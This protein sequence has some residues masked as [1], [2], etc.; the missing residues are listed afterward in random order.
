ME[1]HLVSIRNRPPC[2]LAMDGARPGHA[3]SL[4]WGRAKQGRQTTV[5][6]PPR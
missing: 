6:G 4:I 5:K 3:H 2:Q 1:G